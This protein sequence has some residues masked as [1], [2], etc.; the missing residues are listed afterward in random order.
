[1]RNVLATMTSSVALLATMA[2]CPD[3]TISKLDPQQQG[4]VTKHIPV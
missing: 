3:R 2:G 4:E 1:M